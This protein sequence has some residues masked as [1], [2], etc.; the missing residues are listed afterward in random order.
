MHAYMQR[1]AKNF[2][3]WEFATIFGADR[4]TLERA[5]EN[6]P[7]VNARDPDIAA[8]IVGLWGI[9]LVIYGRKI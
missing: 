6:W 2:S 8:V 3:E 1:K 4:K 5:Y 9:C 7:V